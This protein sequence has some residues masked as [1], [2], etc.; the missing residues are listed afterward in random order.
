MKMFACTFMDSIFLGKK[1][2]CR[3]DDLIG[4]SHFYFE[5]YK[6]GVFSFSRPVSSRSFHRF[7]PTMAPVQVRPFYIS[8]GRLKCGSNFFFVPGWRSH[9]RGGAF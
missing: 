5:A 8:A 1:C 3:Q 7:S 6:E 2:S 4:V 9:S